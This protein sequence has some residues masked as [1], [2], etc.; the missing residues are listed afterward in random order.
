MDSSTA[1]A[2]ILSGL[3]RG[4]RERELELGVAGLLDARLEAPTPLPAREG[5]AATRSARLS[6][7]DVAEA[8]NSYLA[9]RQLV[10]DDQNGTPLFTAVVGSRDRV[11]VVGTAELSDRGSLG[12]VH[13]VPDQGCATGREILQVTS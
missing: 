4:G 13:V 10:V 9:T 1:N 5:R 3:H 11:V 2:G 12:V 6:A 7:A 8:L